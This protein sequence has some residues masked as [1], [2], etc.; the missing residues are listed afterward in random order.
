MPMS[1]TVISIFC[2]ANKKQEFYADTNS[3]H[4][5]LHAKLLYRFQCS[6]KK[7]FFNN[8]VLSF[9]KK[10]KKVRL[11]NLSGNK[12]MIKDFDN[13]IRKKKIAF[14]FV[15]RFNLNEF[16]TFSRNL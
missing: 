7:N 14:R 2:M 12:Q 13:S 10:K 11:V 16:E 8:T 1:R 6:S 4:N 9:T 15:Q 5:N 3:L